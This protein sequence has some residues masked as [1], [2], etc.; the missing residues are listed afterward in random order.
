MGMLVGSQIMSLLGLA[1]RGA[2]LT[3]RSKIFFTLLTFQILE[4]LD[5]RI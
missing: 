2:S 5:C 4:G 1:Y 3:S